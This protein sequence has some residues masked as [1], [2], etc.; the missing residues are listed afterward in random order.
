[1]ADERGFYSKS[2]GLWVVLSNGGDIE[3][4][5]VEVGR[6]LREAGPVVTIHETL[7]LVGYFIG[8]QIHLVG[9][10][11][12]SDAFLSR[13]PA[14]G[15]HRRPGHYSRSFPR[16][17]V[18]SLWKGDNR[19]QSKDLAILY[20]R[21]SLVVRGDLLAPGRLGTILDLNLGRFD[22][23]VSQTSDRHRAMG[24]ATWEDA[25]RL[26]GIAS[27]EK[28]TLLTLVDRL[29][30]GDR[31]DLALLVWKSSVG[32]G[33]DS[34]GVD[35]CQRLGRHLFEEDLGLMAVET[36]ESCNGG[37]PGDTSL[38]NGLAEAYFEQG[39]FFSKAGRATSRGMEKSLEVAHLL[40]AA[41]LTRIYRLPGAAVF[42]ETVLNIDPENRDA[43]EELRAIA[44][45]GARDR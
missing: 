36:L 35:V 37:G 1:M 2:T 25:E 31:A 10:Y 3:H 45:E 43:K 18:K 30:E 27:S 16:G 20:G 24:T 6:G 7:G 9:R 14:S 22:H 39:L 34:L 5:W 28:D 29:I 4:R 41:N 23:L 44:K 38:Q 21:I 17:F 15:D 32:Q 19:I 13:L 33:Q 12:L 26:T 11:G 42:Y 8:P 40:I